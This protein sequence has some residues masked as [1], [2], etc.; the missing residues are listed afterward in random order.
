MNPENY[1]VPRRQRLLGQITEERLS[2]SEPQ[3]LWKY[4]QPWGL[5]P[6]PKLPCTNLQIICLVKID[7]NNLTTLTLTVGYVNIC[8]CILLMHTVLQGI[9]PTLKS[10]P[11]PFLRSPPLKKVLNLSDRPLWETLL[12]ILENLT[13]TTT[14]PSPSFFKETKNPLCINGII[15]AL[16]TIEACGSK[17]RIKYRAYRILKFVYSYRAC[18]HNE[19]K[20]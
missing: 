15:R 1:R 14:P 9:S 3:K 7:Q 20:T 19:K 12:K 13:P 2:N 16:Q 6:D 5:R 8:K 17:W 11:Q 18:R 10:W 4:K